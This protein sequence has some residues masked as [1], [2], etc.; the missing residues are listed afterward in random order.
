MST[1][2]NAEY[3]AK[4]PED[5]FLWRMPYKRLEV[6]AIRDSMLASSGR[7]NR[8]MFGPSVLPEIPAAA[9]EGSSDPDKIWR[10]SSEEEASRRTVYIFLKRSMI[11]PMLDVLDLCDTARSAARRQ[12]T[13]V[14][15]QALTLFNGDFVNRQARYLADRLRKASGDPATQIDLAWRLTLAR[16]PEPR[17]TAAMLE[18]LKFESLDEMCRVIFNLNEFVYAD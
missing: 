16:P 15:T 13:S 10:P 6:E 18:F 11:V 1:A 17:E 12:N 7:L 2:W 3:G 5:R 14:A 9:L 4:D 8:K